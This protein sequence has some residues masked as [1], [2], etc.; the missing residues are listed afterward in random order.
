M[1]VGGWWGLGRE[2]RGEREVGA[3]K[4]VRGRAGG[5]GKGLGGG[6][7]RERE[8]A[9]EGKEAPVVSMPSVSQILRSSF[10]RSLAKL[11]VCGS[12]FFSYLSSHI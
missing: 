5:R 6:R 12:I 10:T 1:G 3:K 9:W 7:R 4:G 11:V 2:S 8:R